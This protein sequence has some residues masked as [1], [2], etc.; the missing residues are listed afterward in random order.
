MTS[1]IIVSRN[2]GL[3][4]RIKALV[5]GIYI[6]EILGAELKL[7]WVEG[8]LSDKFHS[9]QRPDFM[10]SADFVETNVLESAQFSELSKVA[11]LSKI[12][13]T[14]ESWSDLEE[15][16]CIIVDAPLNRLKIDFDKHLLYQ[17]FWSLPLSKRYLEL[18]EFAQSAPLQDQATGIHIRGGDVIYERF[19]YHHRFQEK[20]MP[21]SVGKRVAMKALDAG[22]TPLVFAQDQEVASE[23]R[24]IEGV[25]LAQDIGREL[26][27]TADERA[28]LEMALLSRCTKVISGHTG[29]TELA[30]LLTDSE[31][32][33]FRTVFS[34]DEIVKLV[35]DDLRKNGYRYND[36]HAAFLLLN[37]AL[38]SNPRQAQKSKKNLILEA[39]VRAGELDP[40]NGMYPWLRVVQLLALERLDEAEKVLVQCLKLDFGSDVDLDFLLRQVPL[41]RSITAQRVDGTVIMKRYFTGFG[42]DFSNH[43]FLSIIHAY[44]LKR[45]GEADDAKKMISNVDFAKYDWHPFL[46]YLHCLK[47]AIE[48]E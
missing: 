41:F 25:C 45:Q 35:N 13:D 39:L 29:F 15:F 46:P 23:M 34:S 28:F 11:K 37:V 47:E 31:I 8:N 17:M 5:S 43:P 10:F 48:G 16:D 20:V 44:L 42:M 12:A 22:E 6:S 7:H 9:I 2:D 38:Y 32:I 36:L 33:N 24:R 1:K 18:S 27:P 4:Q 30:E 21:I 19:R 3:S 14:V 40:S 26:N